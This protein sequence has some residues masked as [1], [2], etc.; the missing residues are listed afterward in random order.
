MTPALPDGGS[1]NSYSHGSP[2]NFLKDTN[3]ELWKNLAITEITIIALM[4]VVI[5]VGLIYGKIWR[6]DEN[7]SRIV[8]AF[9]S[10]GINK[11]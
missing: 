1:C 7:A 8:R 11:K 3:M 9:Q 4:V 6:K 10:F 2:F 5:I